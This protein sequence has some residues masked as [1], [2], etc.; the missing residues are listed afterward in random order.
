MKTYIHIRPPSITLVALTLAIITTLLVSEAGLAY[1]NYD[2]PLCRWPYTVGVR[3]W[4]YYKWGNW[5][6]TEW[7]AAYNASVVDW[8]TATDRV[9][10]GY[11][12]GATNTFNMYYS[13]DGRGGYAVWYCSGS[14]MTKTGAWVNDY[15]DPGNSNIR[16]SR[17]GHK[18]GHGVSL[19]HSTVSPSLMGPNPD[20]NVYYTPQQD[21]RNGVYDRF[22]W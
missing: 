7:K 3:K 17:T 22:P 13:A 5:V 2:N 10:Y 6:D 11:S 1:N 21:D 4:L 15:Y 18:L 14:T 12:T 8:N 16:Q 20:P 19:G 9:G